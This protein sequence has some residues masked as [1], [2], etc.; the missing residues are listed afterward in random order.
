MRLCSAHGEAQVIE[1]Y[2]DPPA[3]VSVETPIAPNVVTHWGDVEQMNSD[4]RMVYDAAGPHFF[5]AHPNPEPVG[6]CSSFPTD[7]TEVGPSSYGY[8]VS[9]LS[10][11]FYDVRCYDQVSQWASDLLPRDHTLPS[12]YYSTKKLIRDLG[13]S[14]EKIHACKNGCMLYW[15]DN[16]GLEYCK[17]Y[18]DPMYKP[19]RD[20]NPQCKKSPYAIL[21]YLPLIPR[22][23]RLYALPATTEH[24]TWHACH[25]TEEGSMCHPSDAEAWRHFDQSYPDFAMEPRN[26]RLILC[27]NGFAP[28]G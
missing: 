12:D 18:G 6:A 11:R 14:V 5:L 8:D 2:D 21:R 3:P 9:R 4:Q 17:F 28:H 25:Q 15:K 20:R 16:I 13:F 19:T 1:Y 22:L 24:M 27:T 7:G 10:D 23:L 26:V